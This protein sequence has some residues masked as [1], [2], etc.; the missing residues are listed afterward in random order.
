MAKPIDPHSPAFLEYY[1]GVME[2][3]AAARP[4]H[5]VDWMLLGAA[6]ARLH[7]LLIRREQQAQGDLFAAPNTARKGPEHG[8][9]G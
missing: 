1:A 6:K 8:S 9:N 2:R 5:D 3:E 4:G 7:L